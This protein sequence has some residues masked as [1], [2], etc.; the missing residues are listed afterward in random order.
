MR[1]GEDRISVYGVACMT[2]LLRQR[3]LPIEHL[4]AAVDGKVLKG[5][6]EDVVLLAIGLPDLAMMNLEDTEGTVVG[7]APY[8]FYL[9]PHT[10]QAR[11]VMLSK[12][13]TVFYT[14]Y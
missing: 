1:L 10:G 12:D 5:M 9:D 2:E 4:R 8:W 13:R 3:G 6:H 11:V 14:D 7:K